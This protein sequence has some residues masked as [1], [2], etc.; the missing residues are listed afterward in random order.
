MRILYYSPHPNLNLQDPAGY[1]THMREMIAAFRAMGHDV[2]P[3]I[4]GGTEP[5]SSGGGKRRL[6]FVKSVAKRLISRKRWETLKDRHLM[7]FDQKARE[8]LAA[9]IAAF[10]PDLIYERANYMQVSGVRAAQE[11]GVLHILEVNSPYTEE[12]E[13]LEGPSYL[14]PQANDLEREQLRKTSHVVVVSSSLRDYLVE[15]HGLRASR[16]SVVP[17]AIDPSK[18]QVEPGAVAGLRRD[19]GLEGK[20]VI[21]WV[22]S[23]QPWHGIQLMVE[24]FA[25][26]SE[27]VRQGARL[28][29]VGGGE[30]L[31]EMKAFAAAGPASGQV[32]FTG[33][34]PHEKV[35]PY[36]A[37]MDIC[38]LPN[39]KWYCSPIKIFEY[40]AMGKPVIA[41]NHAA[42]LDVM[43]PDLDGLIIEPEAAVLT[44]ALRKLLP[45]P[46]LRARY[47]A[48]FKE[49]VLSEHT[50]AANARRVA[51]IYQ[52]L[53]ENAVKKGGAAK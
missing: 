11:A 41:S 39:T 29:I 19:L 25:G 28:L 7:A 40:G 42:V 50:W 14:L 51:G 16:F 44:D 30:S 47:A 18:L 46:E 8:H 5:R 53:R 31:E 45:K 1:G 37:G 17:N 2:L 21:G 23:I 52:M 6:G 24:G 43:E 36:L 9:A 38:L 26:L 12:K 35:F 15:K 13:E 48:Q 20:V 3:V 33:Y 27:E 49:K 4:M 10:Q 34:V 32:L 22:G